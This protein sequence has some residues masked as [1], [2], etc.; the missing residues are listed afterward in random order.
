MRTLKDIVQSRQSLHAENAKR[1][2]EYGQWCARFKAD[3]KEL[4]EAET[5]LAGGVD[6]ERLNHGEHV[7]YIRGDYRKVGG[8]SVTCIAAAKADLAAGAPKLKREYFGAKNYA[9]WSGQ[10]CDCTYGM[11]PTHGSI[12]FAIGLTDAARQ[13]ELT[14]EMIEDALYVLANIDKVLDARAKSREAA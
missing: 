8:E 6:L 3:L 11:G 2:Q 9:H 12:V 5:L 4:A 14:D 1:E 13:M 10:R 7:I